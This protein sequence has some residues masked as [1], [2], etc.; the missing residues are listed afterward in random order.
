MEAAL[1]DVASAEP[2]NEPTPP[3]PAVQ[4]PKKFDLRVRE[5]A[6]KQAPMEAVI[7]RET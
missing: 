1:M 2:S 5:L 4:A 6:L 3:P 7:D